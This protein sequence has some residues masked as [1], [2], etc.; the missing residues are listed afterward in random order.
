MEVNDKPEAS[1]ALRHNG[2]ANILFI[3]GHA[4]NPKCW[5]DDDR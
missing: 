2:G 4:S 5:R 1:P 3:D